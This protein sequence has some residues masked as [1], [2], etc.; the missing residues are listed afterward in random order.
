MRTRPHSLA[1]THPCTWA[2]A[3]PLLL[4]AA[5]WALGC[6]PTSSPTASEPKAALSASVLSPADQARIDALVAAL[7]A[8]SSTAP[9]L[10][11]AI[12]PH[13]RFPHW[14]DHVDAFTQDLQA[15]GA[16][17]SVAH[18]MLQAALSSGT[19]IWNQSDISNV[20]AANADLPLLLV[21]SDYSHPG[22]QNGRYLRALSPFFDRYLVSLVSLHPEA[23]GNRSPD[24]L[25][26][27][28]Q[29]RMPRNRNSAIALLHETLHADFAGPLERQIKRLKRDESDTTV[30]AFPWLNLHFP[31]SW[32]RLAAPL[33][34]EGNV[35]VAY[36]FEGTLQSLESEASEAAD[37]DSGWD[38]IALLH[39]VAELENPGVT[40]LATLLAALEPL[41]LSDVRQLGARIAA[42]WQDFAA[43]RPLNA[44]FDTQL[45]Q[46]AGSGDA[47]LDTLL[48]LGLLQLA[49]DTAN[50]EL[51]IPEATR[52]QLLRSTPASAVEFMMSWADTKALQVHPKAPESLG[53]PTSASRL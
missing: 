7:T 37:A 17:V 44:W 51:Y 4:A 19:P 40:A 53:P 9:T 11:V 36:T 42:D 39:A 14:Q 27:Q 18:D 22:W 21:F 45:P 43:G 29:A 32:E 3:P 8:H 2:A 41:P 30:I 31:L 25:A 35:L 5:L 47:M 48:S 28:P 49:G 20:P 38:G 15:A 26:H 13:L 50:P 52:E 46:L 16:Q 10:A 34:R 1:C 24:A 6:A 12:D 23:H 33:P